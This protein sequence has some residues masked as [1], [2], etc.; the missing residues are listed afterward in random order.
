MKD[1]SPL[2]KTLF[3]ELLGFEKGEVYISNF[4][5]E[6]FDH[7]LQNYRQMKPIRPSD[8]S[9]HDACEKTDL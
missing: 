1:I 4:F 5:H 3:F 6:V 2:S 8:P 7:V 9:Y